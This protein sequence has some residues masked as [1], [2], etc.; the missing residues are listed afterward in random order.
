L[1]LRREHST[2][3][4]RMATQQVSLLDDVVVV[5]RT[6]GDQQTTLA[7]NITDAARSIALDGSLAFASD[8]VRW[9]GADATNLDDGS[10]TIAPWTTALVVTQRRNRGS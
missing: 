2:V 1:R 9:G 8:D 3:A 4:G 7:I 10:L 5:T 6:F